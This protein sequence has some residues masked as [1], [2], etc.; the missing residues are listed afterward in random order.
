MSFATWYGKSIRVGE[1]QHRRQIGEV[2]RERLDFHL[3]APRPALVDHDDLLVRGDWFEVDHVDRVEDDGFIAIAMQRQF[4]G[5][6]NGWRPRATSIRRRL[7]ELDSKT[8]VDRFDW[9]ILEERRRKGVGVVCMLGIVDR[10]LSGLA[11]SRNGLTRVKSHR[12]TRRGTPLQRRPH[13][14]PPSLPRARGSAAPRRLPRIRPALSLHRAPHGSDRSC[15]QPS[16]AA[17]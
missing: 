3:A 1:L 13:D 10:D 11:P 16:V 17:S 9:N 15:S 6:C 14:H 8:V 4:D 2:R 12:P 7:C 5:S